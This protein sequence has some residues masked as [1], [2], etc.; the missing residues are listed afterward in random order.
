MT[1]WANVDNRKSVKKTK[2][3]IT[4]FGY[5]KKINIYKHTKWPN[6]SCVHLVIFFLLID[7]GFFRDYEFVVFAALNR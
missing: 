5:L 3:L 4:A 7:E 1:F 2:K 6:D